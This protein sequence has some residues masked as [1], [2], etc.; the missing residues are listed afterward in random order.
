LAL[1]AP[2]D[3]R[4]SR[5]RS[6]LLMEGRRIVHLDH[7]LYAGVIGNEP[8]QFSSVRRAHPAVSTDEAEAAAY[9]ELTYTSLN[10]SDIDVETTNH[11]AAD[12]PV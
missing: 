12:C 10:K 5:V 7:G 6:H 3:N 2:S 11:R 4:D 8:A 9:L 1:L